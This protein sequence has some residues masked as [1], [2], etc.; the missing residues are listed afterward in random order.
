MLKESKDGPWII[1]EIVLILLGDL[2]F[3]I[4]V[5]LEWIK[6]LYCINVV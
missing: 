3:D 4:N 2:N 1:G 5:F 6:S